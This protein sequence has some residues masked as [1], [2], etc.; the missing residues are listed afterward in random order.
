MIHG[1]RNG[2]EIVSAA[3]GTTGFIFVALSAYAM[4]TRKDFSYMGGFLFVGFA[5]AFLLGLVSMAFGMPMLS[6]GVS[7]A[8]V[9]LSSGYILYTMSQLVNNGC[10]NYIIATVCLFTSIFNLFVSLL[11]IFSA[12]AGNR[13]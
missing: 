4:L 11:Q 9:L 13:D 2:T 3:L 1:F 6:I 12:F 10:D 7:M 8:F 5:G